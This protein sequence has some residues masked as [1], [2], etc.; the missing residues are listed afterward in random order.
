MFP[1]LEETRYTA[2]VY[3]RVSSTKQAVTALN[4]ANKQLSE[5]NTNSISTSVTLNVGI[6]QIT[7]KSS[8]TSI[9]DRNKD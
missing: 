9:E 6:L 4:I 2:A 8:D 5:F 7:F 3:I 1:G